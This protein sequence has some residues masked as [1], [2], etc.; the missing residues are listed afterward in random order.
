MD[1]TVSL[2]GDVSASIGERRKKSGTPMQ[3][4]M[5]V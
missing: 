3:E 4:G 1:A 2:M 5:M